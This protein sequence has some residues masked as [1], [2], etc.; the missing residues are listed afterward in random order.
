MN[1][2]LLS[3]M[4]SMSLPVGCAVYAVARWWYDRRRLDRVFRECRERRLRPGPYPPRPR[5]APGA[6]DARR[7]PRSWQAWLS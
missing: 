4:V 6:S 1:I 5:R 3:A 2:F 7:V